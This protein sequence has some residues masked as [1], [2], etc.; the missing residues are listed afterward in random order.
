VWGSGLPHIRL[1][2]LLIIYKNANSTVKFYKFSMQVCLVILRTS[3]ICTRRCKWTTS[4]TQS[5]WWTAS[6]CTERYSC[7][8]TTSSTRTGQR[9]SCT[10]VLCVAVVSIMLKVD[11]AEHNQEIEKIGEILPQ[12]RLVSKHAIDRMKELRYGGELQDDSQCQEDG[13][14]GRQVFLPAME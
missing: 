14:L 3:R 5:T 12:I 4:A 1:S 6:R 9:P 8:T 2:W 11:S 7:S 13:I 10:R